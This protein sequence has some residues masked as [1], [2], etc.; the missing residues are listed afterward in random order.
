MTH[1]AA[2]TP[3]LCFIAHRRLEAP[4]YDPLNVC[5]R[6]GRRIGSFEGI[7]VDSSSQRARYLV[8]DR[9]RL[10][11]DRRLIP[12]PVQ[13][14]VVHQRLNVDV[15]D[16]EAAQWPEFKPGEFRRFNAD[17]ESTAT[18]VRPGE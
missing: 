16:L 10:F 6:E 13:L 2:G 3:R 11:P 12:L 1:D 17:D 9:S 18:L 5:T 4:L 14:D 8:V 7:V 15:D